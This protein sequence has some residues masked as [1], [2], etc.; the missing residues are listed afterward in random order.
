[1]GVGAHRLSPPRLAPN[2][3]PRGRLLDRLDASGAHVITVTAG[4]GYGKSTLL[5]AWTGTRSEPCA[6]LQ[7]EP[8]D[9]DPV[10]LVRSV[11]CSLQVSL[12]STP[13]LDIAAH[14]QPDLIDRAL[15]ALDGELT[16]VEPFILVVDDV[17]LLIDEASCRALDQLVA[18]I[19]HHGR[20][21]LSG[22]TDPPVRTARR[23]LEGDL[24]VVR[25]DDLLLT[26]EESASVFSEIAQ[27]AGDEELAAIARRVGGWPAGAQF[28]LL[29]WRTGDSQRAVVDH[30]DLSTA[31]L[32]GYFQQEFLRTLPDVDR[33]F[34]L[35]TSVLDRLS[36]ELCDAV[37]DT[38][39][40]ADHLE[41]LVR[42]G[43]AFVIPSGRTDV[44]RYHPLFSDML[45]DELRKAAPDREVELRQRAIEWFDAHG[46]YHAVV[47]QALASNG[48]IDPSP[49]I[50]KY[51]LP[52]IARAEVAT[53]GWWL[54][55]FAPE[56]LRTN[57]LLALTA[58]WHALHMNRPDETERWLETARRLSYVGPLPDGTADISTAIAAL[59]MIS[60]SGG[61]LQTAA[62]ARIVRDAGAGAGPWG[63]IAVMLETVALQVT[64]KLTDVRPMFEQAEFETRGLPA[65]HATALAH[66]AL[67]SMRHGD[68][69]A[70]DELRQAMDEIERN[71]LTQFRHVPLAYCALALA[72]ARAGRFEPSL[73]ASTHAENVIRDL[74]G[75]ARAQI[76][77][78]LILADAAIARNDWPTANRLVREAVALLPLEPDA[79][80]LHEWADHLVQR[81]ARH[82]A[83]RIEP[84]LTPAEQRVLQQLATHFTLGE[85]AD[86][87]YVSRNTVKTHTVSIYRKLGV[88]GR[89]EAIERA[90]ELG[91][92]DDGLDER[93]VVTAH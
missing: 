73:H 59:R 68:D 46:E 20:V 44:F 77:Y 69:Q 15:A 80:M 14:V 3:V 29:A 9:N 91:L 74:D 48:L 62:N 60:A 42:S 57:P 8:A 30:T 19:S 86:H 90:C 84:D 41:A 25:A 87:L 22:R 2:V 55:S 82:A 26:D 6:W 28:V 11:M 40:S 81:C 78:R 76:H 35:D 1:L 16:D 85:I 21:V 39:A 47:D 89:S 17:H 7:I 34:L 51:V 33:R 75:V 23:L 27:P 65:A 13:L 4:A 24:E 54:G 36:G 63:G 52:L 32:T 66:L 10:R 83:K 53:L 31:L 12:E 5:S 70:R 92:L 58:A 71:G 50:F 49:W 43:N 79:A 56:D 72:E 67:D 61:A 64:G 93:V 38:S 18:V 45:L 37:L 88:S